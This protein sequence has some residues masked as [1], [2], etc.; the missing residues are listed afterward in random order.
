[1]VTFFFLYFLVEYEPQT[2]IGSVT[3]NTEMAKHIHFA[4]FL[5]VFGEFRKRDISVTDGGTNGRTNE[6]T[7]KNTLMT[8]APYGRNQDSKFINYPTTNLA[9]NWVA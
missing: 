6:R 5:H 1:M 7:T 2:H 3:K 9:A 4:S 8:E